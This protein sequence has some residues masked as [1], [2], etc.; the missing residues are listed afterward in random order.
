VAE[1]T[2][3]T[4]ATTLAGVGESFRVRGF[5]DGGEVVTTE[6]ADAASKVKAARQAS[7]LQDPAA[8]VGL[9]V[10]YDGRP[11]PVEFK[12][13]R[14]FVREPAEGQSVLLRLRRRDRT[15]DRF[16]VVLL[17]NGLNTLG[18]ERLT[19]LECRK[20]VLGKDAPPVEIR[21]F[22]TD[23]AKA[24]AFRVLSS[25][26]SRKNVMNYGPEA[27]TVTL[28]V[29]RERKGPP[30]PLVLDDEGEDMAAIARGVMPST[31]PPSLAALKARL[32][33]GQPGQAA[34]GLVVEG[35]GIAAPVRTVEFHADP[36]PVM[37]VTV[38]YYRP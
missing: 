15:A 5:V 28:V 12:D 27:G 1:F 10:V 32:H 21:G 36:T 30:P 37:V 22:Q 29:F 4:D 23:A 25:E 7:P 6:A 17:V 38:T 11:V 16:G 24:E 26:E 9:E 31:P 13:G 19:P 35:E 34:R 33:A 2:A 18:K 20:W 8:P 14:A 3:S